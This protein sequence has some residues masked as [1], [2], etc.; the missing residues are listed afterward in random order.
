MTWRLP[1]HPSFSTR[2][3]ESFCR[4]APNKIQVFFT[5]IAH[6]RCVGHRPHTALALV[7]QGNLCTRTGWS[8]TGEVQNTCGQPRV[9]NTQARARDTPIVNCPCGG[10]LS[11]RVACV[12]PRLLRGSALQ[13]SR[14]LTATPASNLLRAHQCGAHWPGCWFVGANASSCSMANRLVVSEGR[15]KLTTK[16]ATCSTLC[17]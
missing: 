11:P 13:K 12:W 6:M 2:R 15:E 16:A 1:A 3:R 9:F 7:C 5:Y 4:R 10:S 17:C 8:M 14:N